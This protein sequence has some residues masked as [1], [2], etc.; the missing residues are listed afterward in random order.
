MWTDTTR[1]VHARSGL[2]LPSDLT[3]AEWASLEPLLP[4]ASHVGRP[5]KWPLR[6]IIE[7]ILYLLRGGLPWRM[8]PPCFP[9]VSTVRHWFYLWRD[10]GL[11]LTLNHTLLMASR[12]AIDREASPSAGVI[13]SQSVKATEGGGP[14]GYDA[15]KKTKRRKRHILTD[16]EGNLVHAV[17]HTADIQDRDGAPLVLRGII[18]RFPWLRHV[19]ADGGYAGDKL[20][21]ALRRMGKWTVEVIKRS[22]SAKGFEVLPRRWVIERT[23]A[24]LNHNRRLAKD[25]EQT[26]ASATA[27]L[28]IASVQFFIRRIARA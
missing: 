11:W 25:F 9:P 12:Q 16:T 15:D 6:R 23:L 13:D 24:W 1:A 2:T 26:I 14:R 21:D 17:I 4:P 28:Y 7:A 19:F 18:R 10:N 8:L 3:D 20:G 5:R 27:W 22:D